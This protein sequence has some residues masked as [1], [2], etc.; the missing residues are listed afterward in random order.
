MQKGEEKK[1]ELTAKALAKLQ[2]ND[3]RFHSMSAEDV[4][5]H[6]GSSTKT[7]LNNA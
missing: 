7:G 2:T 3:F 6:L 4:V 5:K 1:I